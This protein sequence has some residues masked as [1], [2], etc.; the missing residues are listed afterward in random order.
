MQR[1]RDCSRRSE[2]T[3]CIVRVGARRSSRNPRRFCGRLSGRP[4]AQVDGRN[5]IER[6]D[7]AGFHRCRK[8]SR[9]AEDSVLERCEVDHGRTVR[10]G[11]RRWEHKI[12]KRRSIQRRA[13]CRACIIPAPLIRNAFHTFLRKCAGGPMS[14]AMCSAANFKAAAYHPTGRICHRFRRAEPA[15]C[16]GA[17]RLPPA[18]TIHH[19][20]KAPG[21]A[22]CTLRATQS[23]FRVIRDGSLSLRRGNASDGES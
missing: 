7:T 22:I 23:C 17:S 8:A 6:A 10:A 2:A 20:V 9:S 16:R 14:W 1:R 15:C 18:I 11:R 13:R 4:A 19:A 5:P 21:P 12:C 3:Q